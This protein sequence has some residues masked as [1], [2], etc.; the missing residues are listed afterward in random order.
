MMESTFMNIGYARV[1]TEDQNCENQITKLRDAG[2]DRIFQENASGGKWN[3]TEWHKALT[4]LRKGDVLVV[5][6]LDRLSRSLSDLIWCMNKVKETGAGFKSLTEQID[7]TSACGELVFHMLGAFAQFERA[8][9][10]ERTKLGLARARAQGHKGGNTFI[11]SDKRQKELA[12]RILSGEIRQ[13]EAAE[14][15]RLSQATISRMVARE[16]AKLL[17]KG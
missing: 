1:S 13:A 11:L 3:R 8:L 17:S 7:T 10:Q 9:I 14:E 16:K 2:C 4:Q 6:K 15:E 12:R 5:W